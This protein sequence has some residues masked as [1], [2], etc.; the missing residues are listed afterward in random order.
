ML[1]PKIKTI[2]KFTAVGLKT[3][4]ALSQE[5]IV[6]LWR[7]FM[8]K[9]KTIQ[10]RIDSDLIALQDYRRSDPKDPTS[11]FDM[12]ALT[13]VRVGTTAPTS[14]Q[15]LD[16]SGGL[17]AI[18]LLKGHDVTG[19]MDEIMNEWLP[20]SDYMLDNSRPHFQVMGDKYKNN[21]PDSEEDFY[22]PL[23]VK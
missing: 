18:F 11:A 9:L 20:T 15:M 7:S 12:W 17:Y 2:E 5:A 10:G 14:L 4:T 22:I 6:S 19:L 23:A 16:V 1:T 8:P 21:Q 13:K 3:R